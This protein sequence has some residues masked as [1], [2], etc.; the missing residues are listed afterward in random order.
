MEAG[1]FTR[2]PVTMLKC[3]HGWEWREVKARRYVS[4]EFYMSRS[5]EGVQ[6]VIQRINRLTAASCSGTFS[7]LHTG[8]FVKF[9]FLCASTLCSIFCFF[10]FYSPFS[11][12]PSWSSFLQWNLKK[13]KRRDQV[14]VSLNLQ[15]P[16][17]SAPHLICS[18]SL[19]LNA[20]Q[21]L[22]WRRRGAWGSVIADVRSKHRLRQREEWEN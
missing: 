22:P 17:I 5:N 14:F 2:P 9:L 21:Q 13:A 20:S 1:L 16:A 19:A 3:I 7:Q 15:H 6:S 10:I 8:L 12:I 18:Y 11:L 4:Y